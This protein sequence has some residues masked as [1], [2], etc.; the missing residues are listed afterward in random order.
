MNYHN[1]IK[2]RQTQHAP[3]GAI[4]YAIGALRK[5]CDLPSFISM[6]TSLTVMLWGSQMHIWR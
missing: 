6:A 2:T 3:F 1:Q 4:R 5:D